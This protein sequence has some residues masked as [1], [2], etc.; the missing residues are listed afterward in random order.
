MVT[1]IGVAAEA[2]PWGVMFKYY[3]FSTGFQRVVTTIDLAA[4]AKPWGV[5]FKYQLLLDVSSE[6]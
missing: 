5:M 1:T 4:E 3:V 2:K 6:W